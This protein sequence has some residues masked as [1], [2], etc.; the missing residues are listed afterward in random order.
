M[1]H[2]EVRFG[3]IEHR[4]RTARMLRRR[5]QLA[6]LAGAGITLVWVTDNE[7]F[8]CLE[9]L[10]K[11]RVKPLQP[12]NWQRGIVPGQFQQYLCERHAPWNYVETRLQSTRH[13]NRCGLGETFG[14]NGV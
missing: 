12:G 11:R 3:E 10:L 9:A 1:L 4:Q 5:H 6:L 8:P 2:H 14:V 7:D 13:R